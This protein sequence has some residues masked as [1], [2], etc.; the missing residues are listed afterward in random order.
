MFDDLDATLQAL[1]DDAAAPG[2]GAHRGR[3]LR[4]RR[5]RTSSPTQATLNLF[6]HEV[7]RIAALRDDAR[8]T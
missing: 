8:V 6:L 1:L 2:G 5:T 7:R 3:Q 4:R